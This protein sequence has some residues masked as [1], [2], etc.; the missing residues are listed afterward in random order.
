MPNIN[1]SRTRSCHR[2]RTCGNVLRV[3]VIAIPSAWAVVVNAQTELSLLELAAG[4]VA[5]AEDSKTSS[6][7]WGRIGGTEAER[8]SARLLVDQLRPYVDEAG[9]EAFSFNAHRPRWWRVE[10]GAGSALESAMPAPFDAK[11]PE[12]PIKAMIVQIKNEADWDAVGGKWAFLRATMKGS[13]ARTNVRTQLLYQRAVK[14][15]AAGF[16]FALPTPPGLWQTVVPV[17]KPF[18]KFDTFFEDGVRPI[19]AFCVDTDDGT[20]IEAVIGLDATLTAALTHELDVPRRALNTVATLHG[21]PLGKEVVIAAHLDSFFTGA[22][23]DASGLAVMVG[24]AKEL[25]ELGT[26]ERKADFLFLGLSG[27]HD[28]GAG[29][30]AFIADDPYR[31]SGSH[32]I[33]LEHLDAQFGNDSDQRWPK[34]LNDSR[35]AYVGPNPRPALEAVLPKLVTETGLMT[36]APNVV[37]ACI[38]DLFVVCD[39]V[40]PF[41]LIQ[42][43]PYYHT[44]HDTM[45]KL[46]E[47]GLRNAVEF[48]MRLLE[49]LGA[50]TRETH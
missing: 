29:M 19:P 8:Q 32:M 9:V 5:I 3:L 31:I 38:A 46:S 26:D 47:Q 33:L 21:P 36:R 27:H 1:S 18:A 39:Q 44:N 37:H 10:I 6:M 22:H 49:E 40:I 48:H 4:H 43:A 17:D 42:S 45:D 23:D 13:A 41:T 20:R 25:S 24:L 11:F 12:G 30:R 16:I 14:A 7:L 35:A 28:A 50:I 2:T 34:I 15:G